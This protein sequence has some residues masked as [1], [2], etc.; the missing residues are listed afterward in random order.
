[1]SKQIGEALIDR[2]LISRSQLEKALQSQ[3]I[4]GGHLGTSLIELGFIEE[5]ALGRT[6]AEIHGLRHASKEVFEEIPPTI[7]QVLDADLAV[8]HK[9]V[10]I[11][12]EGTTLHLAMIQAKNLSNLSRST[13]YKIVP[14]VAPEI[15]ILSAL[16]R[17]YGIAP[18]R[19]FIRLSHGGGRA[20]PARSPGQPEPGDGSTEP[21]PA[22]D[23]P[24]KR[25][26]TLSELGRAMSRVESHWEL[27]DVILNHVS[28]R[29]PR[30]ILF[31]VRGE[32]ARPVAWIGRELD[33]DA[34]GRMKLP[35]TPHSIFATAL[36]DCYYRGPIPVDFDCE[37]FYE[38]LAIGVPREFLLLPIYGED[39]LEAILY[40]DGGTK[41]KIE[42][43]TRSYQE[44]SEMIGMAMKMLTL[45]LQLC[46]D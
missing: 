25:K 2:G 14:Y 13:G 10:P 35:V 29:L 41:S 7:L 20:T 27:A 9:V 44:L 8:K 26:S 28:K 4:L 15:Q 22:A 36:D 45:K 23:P 33:P 6:L 17:Y 1:M 38:E 30:A 37:S 31:E 16:E 46:P 5:P 24:T 40:G 32:E 12:L 19:R 39:R 43:P 34:M 11:G 3:L 42:D 18:R 21:S